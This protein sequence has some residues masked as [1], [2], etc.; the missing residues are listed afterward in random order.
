[1]DIQINYTP[2]VLAFTPNYF[3]PAATCLFSILKHSDESDK[4]EVIVLLSEPLPERMEQKLRLLGGERMDFTFLNLEGKLTDIYVNE[5]YTVAASY[6]LLLPE[7]LPE[8]D[9]IMYIDC[10]VIVRNNLAELY[11]KVD[12]K[13]NY[14]AGI[15]E[16]TLDIQL[17]HM[18]EIGCL[19]GEYINSGFLIMNLAKLREDA[20]S[21][22]FIEA[23]KA[24]YLEFPDQDVINQLCKGRILGLPPA[25]N[26]IRTFYLP[27][28]KPFF[29]NYYSE[30]DWQGVQ[31]HGTVHYTGGKPW[32]T[33]TVEFL[34][35]WRYYEQLPKE[36]KEEWIVNKKML[37]FY[38]F[39]KTAFGSFVINSLQD[40][41][42]KLKY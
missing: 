9:K 7:L 35:W 24:D 15:F 39:Y 10:D 14:M 8:K 1:M 42:R 13:D 20:M 40:L 31:E 22:K 18:Q 21:A 29:L 19:P 27:Q 38:H 6:R 32:N 33:F 3:V 17:P 12:L 26:S 5:K 28:Y 36:V 34:T 41:Y 2:L 37:R 25:Y 16:A 11:R 23:S 4:Y 30:A